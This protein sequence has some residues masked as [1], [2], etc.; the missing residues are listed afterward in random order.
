MIP[1]A[2]N[3]LLNSHCSNLPVP[4]G[5]WLFQLC[6]EAAELP[7]K[8]SSTGTR[9]GWYCQG[10][11]VSQPHAPAP[12]MLSLGGHLPGLPGIELNSPP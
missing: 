2:P 12:L 10:F 3:F 1:I 8:L 11:A 6:Q 7:R 5:A 4:H 9:T